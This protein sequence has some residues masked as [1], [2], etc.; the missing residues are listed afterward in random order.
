MTIF[1][2]HSYARQK[3]WQASDVLVGDGKIQQRLGCA[4]IL[5]MQ[6]RPEDVPQPIRPRFEKLLNTLTSKTEAYSYKPSV[7]R[8][9][10]PQSGKLA[11]EIFSIFVE[12]EGGI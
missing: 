12:L 5:L 6:L 11:Q 7:I 3:F 1:S 10:S 4:A 8:V 2:H 9:R